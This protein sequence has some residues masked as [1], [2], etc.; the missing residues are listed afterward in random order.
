MEK[1]GRPGVGKTGS[2]VGVGVNFVSVE[3]RG[4]N[5]KRY[6]VW[7]IKTANVITLVV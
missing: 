4:G 1:S 7:C 5:I 3:W 6:G 2:C